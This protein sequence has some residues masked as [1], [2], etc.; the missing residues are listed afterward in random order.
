MAF[1]GLNR[2]SDFD[3]NRLQTALTPK[4]TKYIPIQPTP[5]QTAALLMDNVKELLYGGAA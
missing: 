3:L 2:L 1:P 5:K 4:W